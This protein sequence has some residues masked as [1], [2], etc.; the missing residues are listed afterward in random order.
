[1][2]TNTQKTANFALIAGILIMLSIGVL[3]AW[4]VIK[5]ELI[6]SCGWSSSEAGL[7][8]TLAIVFLALGVF[9]GGRIQDKIGPKWVITCG[10]TLAGFGMIFSGLVGNSPIGIAIGFG[11]I[12]GLGIGLAYACAS[13]PA[14]KWNHPS[15]KGMVA[16][17][18]VGG[19]GMAAIYLAP[20]A[21]TLLSSFG[22]KTTLMILGAVPIMVCVPIAQFVKN[23]PVGYV[24]EAP[25]NLKETAVKRAPAIDF[26][27][28]EMMKTKRFYMLFFMFLFSSSAG[29]LI[30]GNMPKI[31]SLQLPEG[32]ATP[33]LLAGLVAF[34]AFTNTFGRVLGGMMSDKIGPVNAIFVVFTLQML[35]MIGFIFYAN[36]ATLILG[37]I[38]IGFSFGTIL[39]VFPAI[40]AG[41][42]G[43]KNFGANYG[44]MFLAWGLSGAVAPTMAD[45]FY[46]LHK[47]FNT[48]YLLCAMVMVVLIFVN[49]MYK[50][51]VE[52]I[53]R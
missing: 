19:F 8:Y 9:I 45:Y 1:M 41:Q 5:K 2:A 28:S 13:P 37:I 51:N 17:L 12:S 47:N 22:I 14:L 30:L 23:P 6:I 39:S 44:V 52:T 46:D 4:S 26:T 21:S 53:N 15:K 20:L 10:G 33:A 18:I 24:P 3:Y 38:A 49:Y 50:R 25:K 31:A 36:L 43:L 48:A 7:P 29:L 40:T 16:G 42:Y 11:I 27:L 32:T 34:L 35:N